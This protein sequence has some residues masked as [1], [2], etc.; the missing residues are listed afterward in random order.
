MIKQSSGNPIL[1][2]ATPEQD[3]NMYLFQVCSEFKPIE[4]QI[5][6]DNVNCYFSQKLFVKQFMSV[7][8]TGTILHSLLTYTTKEPNNLKIT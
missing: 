6:G 4:E 3:L 8:A 2:C 5:N 7:N 1:S